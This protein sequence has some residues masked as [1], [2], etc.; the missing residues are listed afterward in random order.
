VVSPA[1][2]KLKSWLKLTVFTRWFTV[3][4][5][6]AHPAVYQKKKKKKKE[7]KD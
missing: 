4:H 3:Q 1:S 2:S 7:G 6:H 5:M